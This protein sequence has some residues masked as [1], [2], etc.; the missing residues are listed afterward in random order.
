MQA[1]ARWRWA[2]A[3]TDGT[4]RGTPGMSGA[5][6]KSLT[7][8]G[9][10]R[11]AGF[12]FELIPT[13]HDASEPIALIVTD[14]ASGARLGVV[15]DLGHWTPDIARRLSRLDALVLEANHDEEMLRHG[16]Y[17]PFLQARIAGPDGHLSN[18]DAG[19]LASAVSHRGLATIVLAHLSEQ[20]NR[21]DVAL[22]TVAAHLARGVFAGALLAASQDGVVSFDVGGTQHP[23]QLA[24]EF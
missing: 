13:P 17:P 18:A 14:Q 11:A 20:N 16:P 23:R 1:H 8:V 5:G 24:L 12:V 22:A 3:A 10:F 7:R 15:Y 21:P 19:R 4:I 2:L 9:A 6:T